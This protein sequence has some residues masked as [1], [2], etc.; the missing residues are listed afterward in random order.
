[1]DDN[2]GCRIVLPDYAGSANTEEQAAD[3]LALLSLAAVI[4]TPCNTLAARK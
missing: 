1:L 4:D 2:S 3:S